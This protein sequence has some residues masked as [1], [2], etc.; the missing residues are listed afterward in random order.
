MSGFTKSA[1]SSGTRMYFMARPRTK[2]SDWD[3]NLV[4]S[5]EVIVTSFKARFIKLSL[6][7]RL[8]L[9]VSPF[10]NSTSF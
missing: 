2:A 5:R 9:Y 3:Q 1:T 8:P 7:T 6:P 4:P 10:F